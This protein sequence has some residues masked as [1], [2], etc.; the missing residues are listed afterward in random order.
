MTDT[1]TVRTVIGI[2]GNI[3]SF[4]L[5]LSPIPTMKKILKQKAVQEFKPDPYLAT[6]LNCAMWTFYGLPY[7]KEDSIL[8]STINA[9]GLVI[10]FIYVAICFIFS[11][12]K[13]RSKIALVL[14]VEV[15]IMIAVV[16]ISM[17]LFSS[18]KTRATF[19]GILCIILNILMYV[20]PLTVMKLVIKTKSVKYMPL[21]LS[22]ANLANGIIW[23]IYALLRFDI[24]IVLPN[25][26]GVISGVIQI[27]LYATYYRTTRW[28]NDD[29]YHTANGSS[30]VQMASRV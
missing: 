15:L 14:A 21:M 1:A 16:M 26:L 29:E 28:D 27:I 6:V 13:K 9:I 11:P 17:V 10:E 23:V 20:S 5:F 2:I 18:P 24:N 19:V 4:C 7:V 8:V 30:E 22:L 12:N 3:I 25:G